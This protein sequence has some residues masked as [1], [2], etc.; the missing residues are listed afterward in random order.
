MA[1]KFSRV[2]YHLLFNL[3]DK[4]NIFS[5]LYSF[6]DGIIFSYFEDLLMIDLEKDI[7]EKMSSLS[8]EF[9]ILL[10][11]NNLLY[12]FLSNFITN[13]ICSKIDLKINF[14]EINKDFCIKNKITNQENL[15]NFLSL[16]G[17]SLEDHKKNL[18]NTEKVKFIAS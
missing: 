10:K 9:I 6:F 4:K 13:I 17:I 11:E 18:E 5:K 3:R 1:V 16:K 8:N 7:T 14:E 15:L 2:L 12:Q